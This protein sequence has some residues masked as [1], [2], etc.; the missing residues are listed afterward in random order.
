[1][2]GWLR[3]EAAR[4]STSNRLRVSGCPST[5]RAITLMATSRC[6]RVSRARN[7]SPMPPAPRRSR[8]S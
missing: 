6:R 4:A 1:M 8:I 3:A 2:F 5:R 7:T